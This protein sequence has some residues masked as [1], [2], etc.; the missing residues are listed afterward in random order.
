LNDFFPVVGLVRQVFLTLKPIIMKRIYFSS[1]FLLLVFA[2]FGQTGKGSWLLGGN[3]AFSSTSM[4]QN[5]NSSNYTLFGFNPKI[6][7]FP[8]N[9]F[10]VILNT[11]YV[12]QSGYHDLVIGPA[13]RY[14]FPGSEIVRLFVG[15]G[16]GFG[17][18]ESA[19][20]TT[21][22]FEAGPA[23]FIRPSI[24]LE[25]NVYYHTGTT[26]YDQS[27][28]PYYNTDV[29]QSEFGV[30]LGFMVYLDKKKK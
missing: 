7:V 28:D 4:K 15:G 9:N 27:G 16:V 29:T 19:H 24:A 12:T 21:Y 25:L 18:R 11:D 3:I 13:V 6:G 26:K 23:I 14:Y 10:A 22:Q 30:G 17:S 1:V 2:G 5:G 8:V 20:S